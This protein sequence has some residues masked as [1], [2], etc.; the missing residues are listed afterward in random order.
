MLEYI[1][2]Y[3][4][5]TAVSGAQYLAELPEETRFELVKYNPVLPYA[6]IVKDNFEQTIMDTRLKENLENG[7]T[8]PII[9]GTIL[10]EVYVELINSENVFFI[11]E[12]AEEF[13]SDKIKQNIE[14]IKLLQEKLNKEYLRKLENEQVVKEDYLF[15]NHI[16]NDVNDEEILNPKKALE[17]VNSEI[18][19]K[20]EVSKNLKEEIAFTE[21]DIRNVKE[22]LAD[23]RKEKEETEQEINVLSEIS[24]LI[25][26]SNVVSDE[27]TKAS[28]ELERLK[29]EATDS[30]KRL[31]ATEN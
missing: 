7:Y 23:L 8:V 26:E 19:G 6:I 25:T 11:G 30:S 16:V 10:A 31:A 3:H 24:R 14:R 27:K 2:R 20:I 21:N 12:N 17:K 18:L 5:N 13:S 1:R 15:I 4:S 22:E 29:K 28:T 9:Y